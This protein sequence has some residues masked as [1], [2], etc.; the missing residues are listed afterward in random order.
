[1]LIRRFIAAL[2]RT[3]RARPAGYAEAV[4]ARA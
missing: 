1:M 2:K 4:L 3:A